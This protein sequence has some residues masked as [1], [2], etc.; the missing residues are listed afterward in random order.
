VV[1]VSVS[2]VQPSRSTGL[3]PLPLTR[4]SDDHISKR[5]SLAPPADRAANGYSMQTKRHTH[6]RGPV[7]RNSPAG[8]LLDGGVCGRASV[9]Q[10]AL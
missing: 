2:Q 4:R 9:P 10:P 3:L 8:S 7:A 5:S 6:L 1:K